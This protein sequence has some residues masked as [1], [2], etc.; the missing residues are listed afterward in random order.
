MKLAGQIVLVPFPFSNLS[1]SKLRPVLLLCR[2]S[3]RFDDWLVCMVSSKLHHAE[4]GLDE[5][6]NSGD[7]DF[8]TTGLKAPSLLRLTRLAV[9][10]GAAMVGSL[11]NI[12]PERVAALRL[13]LAQWLINAAPDEIQVAGS[14]KFLK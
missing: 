10:D 4:P 11:G 12:P 9:I 5:I 13:R 8:A 1:G 7:E 3:N 6:L 2:A 14:P